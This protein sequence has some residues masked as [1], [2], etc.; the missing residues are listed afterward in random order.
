MVRGS[1]FLVVGALLLAACSSG[2]DAEPQPLDTLPPATTAAPASDD[3]SEPTVPSTEAAES[4]D[5]T[6]EPEPTATDAPEPPDIDG[7]VEVF[8]E[9]AAAFNEVQLNPQD[10]SI[11]PAAFDLMTERFRADRSFE[12]LTGDPE[13]LDPWKDLVVMSEAEVSEDGA[14]ARLWYCVRLVERSAESDD[15]V[16]RVLR[17]TMELVEG[18]WKW[19]DRGAIASSP[20][21][22]GCPLDLD[23]D[24]VVDADT[25]S[26][27]EAAAI[28]FFDDFV[29]AQ[30]SPSDEAV[31]DRFTSGLTGV[32]LDGFG[33]Y[34]ESLDD[35]GQALAIDPSVPAVSE[36]VSSPVEQD[37]GGIF[38][39]ACQP[40]AS[41]IGPADAAR[42]DQFVRRTTVLGMLFV[43]D[44]DGLLL[45]ETTTV[46][47]LGGVARCEPSV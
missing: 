23:L 33:S 18:E 45:A 19:A 27:V 40:L 11:R 5:T 28:R 47:D 4:V 22:Q 34:V 26:E 1:G 32:V 3:T 16:S 24:A 30:Q 17:A 8:R 2:S 35:G 12:V 13:F 9:A 29:A 37:D 41:R 14:S 42:T 38:V 10:E 39:V 44:D 43:R 6:P 46:S 15:A 7:P 20:Q 25:Q 36:V 31:V 21:S